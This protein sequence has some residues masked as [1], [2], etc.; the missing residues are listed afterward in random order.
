MATNVL[1]HPAIQGSMDRPQAEQ[2]DQYTIWQMLGILA[3]VAVPMALLVWVVTPAIIPYSPLPPGITYWL[4]I[5]VGMAWEFVVAL[6]IIYREL[7]TLRWSAIRQR[8]R[9]E[10]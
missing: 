4:A 5:I 1:S 10:E 2:L 9:S 6:V 3:L 7:G 8:T